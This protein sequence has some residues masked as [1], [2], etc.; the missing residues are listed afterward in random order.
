MPASAV[1]VIG[2]VLGNATGFKRVMH[3]KSVLLEAL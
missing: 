3:E 1:N 2:K